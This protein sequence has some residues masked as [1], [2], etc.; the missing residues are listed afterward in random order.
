MSSNIVFRKDFQKIK[1]KNVQ[2]SFDAMQSMDGRFGEIFGAVFL[3]TKISFFSN[4]GLWSFAR[5]D[6][7]KF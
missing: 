7:A 1:E 5:P 3:A 6:Y 2:S 4:L